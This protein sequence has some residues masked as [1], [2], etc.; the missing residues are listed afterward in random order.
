MGKLIDPPSQTAIDSAIFS[1][2]KIG[3]LIA[4]I[5][6]RKV[7][8]TPLVLHLAGIPAPPCIGKLLVMG[9]LLGC[10]SAALAVAVRC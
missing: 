6:E 9:A 2:V 10:R 3:A 1:L 4:S 8:L 7:T 5:E